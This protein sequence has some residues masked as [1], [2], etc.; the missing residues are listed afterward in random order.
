MLDGVARVMSLL[1]IAIRLQLRH[2][3]R[4]AQEEG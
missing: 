2:I 1:H 4:A 3:I